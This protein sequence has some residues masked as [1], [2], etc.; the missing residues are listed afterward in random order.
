[1]YFASFNNNN[2]LLMGII[3]NMR[4]KQVDVLLLPL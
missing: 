3:A 2:K 4:V 1:M